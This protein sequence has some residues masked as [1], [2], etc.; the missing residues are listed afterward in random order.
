LFSLLSPPFVANIILEI[1][2]YNKTPY[3]A[4]IPNRIEAKV[5]PENTA[6]IKVLEKVGMNNE[7][8][9]KDYWLVDHTYKDVFIKKDWYN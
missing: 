1:Y 4:P 6:S 7:G 5:L 3:I 9:L 8:Y 2:F